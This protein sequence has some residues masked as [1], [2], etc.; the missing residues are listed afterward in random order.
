[1]QPRAV[2]NGAFVTETV[3]PQTGKRPHAGGDSGRTPAHALQATCAVVLA[4]GRGSRLMPLT[5]WRS[6][7]A[8]PFAGKLKHS[9]V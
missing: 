4:G 5:D 3:R 8:M 2:K 6:K 9:Q 1:M 7:P